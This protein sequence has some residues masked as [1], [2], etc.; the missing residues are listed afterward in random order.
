MP[1]LHHFIDDCCAFLV[2]LPWRLDPRLRQ[3]PACKL[4][5]EDPESIRR[6]GGVCHDCDYA[7]IDDGVFA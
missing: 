4:T 3:C 2:T 6:Q 7:R 5:W 1:D